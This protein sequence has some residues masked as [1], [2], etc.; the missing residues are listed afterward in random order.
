MGLSSNSFVLFS[1]KASQ[2]VGLSR[3]LHSWRKCHPKHTHRATDHLTLCVSHTTYVGKSD[4]V[5]TFHSFVKGFDRSNHWVSLQALHLCKAYMLHKHS[6][7]VMWCQYWKIPF[8]SQQVVK[9]SACIW[10]DMPSIAPL[11]CGV[12]YV[13]KKNERNGIL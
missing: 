9:E 2:C 4:H 12:I 7:A 11:C 13:Q 6:V 5:K 1:L 10:I 3:K 8:N